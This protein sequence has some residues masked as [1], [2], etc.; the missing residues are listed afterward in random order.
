MPGEVPS[1]VFRLEHGY[2]FPEGLKAGEWLAN[3]ILLGPTSVSE[4][5]ESIYLGKLAEYQQMA[6]NVWVDTR[7]AHAIYVM[8]KRRSGKTF[9]LG[10]LAEG[11]ASSS[12]IQQGTQRQAILLLDTMNVFITM[13]YTVQDVYGGSSEEGKELVKWKIEAETPNIKLFHPRGTSAPPAT[14]S[15]EVAIRPSDLAAE[16]WASI[17]EVDTY[18]DPIGQL[19]SE[20]YDKVATEGYADNQGNQV[21]PHPQFSLDELVQCLD[22]A[23][24][25]QRF[26]SRTI[27]AVRRRLRAIR[28]IGIFS[29]KGIDIKQ[30]LIPGQISVLMLRDLDH[31][32]RGLLIGVIVKKIMSLRSIAD[33]FERLAAIELAKSQSEANKEPAKSRESFEKYQEYTNLASEGIPRSWLIIDEAHNYV[34]SSGVI[35]SKEPL[36][37][38]INEGRNLGLSIAVATQQ[39][40]GLDRS[41]QRNADILIIHPMSMRDDIE[42]THGMINTFVPDSVVCDGR[43]RITSRMFEQLVRSLPRGYALVSNDEL[44]RILVIKVRPRFTVHG[45]KEY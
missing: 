6:K 29:D 2:T 33:R 32:L 36:K 20:V 26:E 41:I 35:G 14:P 19:L 22:T 30:L 38:Y 8:G 13:P 15:L 44:S 28:R 34:P 3:N 1:A 40:S 45:G 43:E 39:P 25:I 16:D 37:K 24:E 23:P 42:A 12:W 5:V 9:T 10:V 21:P 31:V 17:F 27:E 18:S 4:Q 7:G 11:L